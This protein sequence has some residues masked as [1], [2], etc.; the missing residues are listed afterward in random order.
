MGML[1]HRLFG[2]DA[3]ETSFVRR[4]FPGRD[5][6]LR[7]RLEDFAATFVRGYHAGL[8]ETEPGEL[9]HRLEAVALD[10]RGFAYEG[11]GMAL[12][13]LD[14][15]TPWNRGRVRAFLDGPGRTHVYMVHVGVGWAMARLRRRPDRWLPRFDPLFG[16]LIMDG[17]GF[18]QGFF[19]WRR[20]VE[21]RTEPEHL[22]SYDRRMF[23]QGL[24]RCLWFVDG[25]EVERIE[26]TIA[27]FPAPRRPDMWSGVGL[28]CAYAGGVDRGRIEYLRDAA[29]SH[30][31]QLAQ[32]VAFAAKARQLAG[33]MAPHTELAC[34]VILGAPAEAAA[35]VTDAALEDLP[36]DG[37]EP[38]YEVWRRRI[39]SRYTVEARA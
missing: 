31:S 4:G 36:P 5:S 29:G 30:V 34:E 2:I 6:P 8:L 38:A 10:V 18:H 26:G 13:L 20:W 16:R 39:Q 9:G 37:V 32:G 19:D 28:A 21:R 33:N 11:A 24:G 23:D 22:A 7:E 1:R 17:Y 3:A 14:M 25:A 35:R 27:G 12:A 15:L